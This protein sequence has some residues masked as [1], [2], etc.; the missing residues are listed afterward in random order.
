MS[1]Q[2]ASAIAC[3]LWTTRS[4]NRRIIGKRKIKT[5]LPLLH[6]G[7]SLHPPKKSV[8]FFYCSWTKLQ[9]FGPRTL[10]T[11]GIFR[12]GDISLMM[13]QIHVY[14]RNLRFNSKLKIKQKLV[15]PDRNPIPVSTSRET[16]IPVWKCGTVSICPDR[17]HLLLAV[18]LL[19][20]DV[21]KISY[22]YHYCHA[23]DLDSVTLTG[24]TALTS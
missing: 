4:S 11:L 7:S 9:V 20:R 21:S 10:F 8:L 6:N 24:L 12:L 13:L 23:G 3:C 17:K 18:F 19:R 15:F 2:C 14:E 16:Y 22:H 1:F 5:P